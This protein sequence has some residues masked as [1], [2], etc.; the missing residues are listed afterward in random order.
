MP[1]CPVTGC[2]YPANSRCA[3]TGCPGTALGK[4]AAVNADRQA[5][6][7]SNKHSLKI[8]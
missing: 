3:M 1:T 7:D 5:R 6:P 2:P 8:D 4:S